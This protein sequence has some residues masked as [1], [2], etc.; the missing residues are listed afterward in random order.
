MGGKQIRSS[1]DS[2]K[3]T[4]GVLSWGPMLA[5]DL[6]KKESHAWWLVALGFPWG[7][8]VR[9]MLELWGLA[10]ETIQRWKMKQRCAVIEVF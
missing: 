1:C 4:R 2:R 5:P 7:V 8:M 9:V 6:T 10:S 3:G